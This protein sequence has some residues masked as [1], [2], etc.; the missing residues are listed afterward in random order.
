[1]NELRTTYKGA[2]GILANNDKAIAELI[3]VDELIIYTGVYESVASVKEFTGETDDTEAKKLVLKPTIIRDK[4]FHVD[5]KPL[6][7]V[8]AFEW[9]TNENALLIETLTAGHVD[10][11][12]AGAVITLP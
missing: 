3:D 10:Q 8:E 4:A 1:M 12:K 7:R 11:S 6:T 2:L 5:M 9:K